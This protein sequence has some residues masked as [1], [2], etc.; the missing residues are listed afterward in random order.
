VVIDAVMVTVDHGESAS[1]SHLHVN[2]FP[3][4]DPATDRRANA[5]LEIEQRVLR[6]RFLVDLA[7]SSIHD[8]RASC[9]RC[10]NPFLCRSNFTAVRSLR[11]HAAVSRVY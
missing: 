4:G 5:S 11:A 6:K 9:P 8:D 3:R 10:R 1:E 2:G 7:I